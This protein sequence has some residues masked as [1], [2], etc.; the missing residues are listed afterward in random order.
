ML[1]NITHFLASFLIS[2]GI[3]L[4]ISQRNY[5]TKLMGLS[6]MQSGVLIFFIG[7]GKVLNAPPPIMKEGQ[8]IYSNLLPQV[9]MLT[10]IVVGV[11]TISIG[12]ALIA[13]INKNFGTLD[14]ENLCENKNLNT[15]LYDH[16]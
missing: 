13:K 14:A 15:E 8:E 9:L 3:F 6:I 5:M 4:S 1:I 12:I 10:A 2:F 11:A 7:L 16:R